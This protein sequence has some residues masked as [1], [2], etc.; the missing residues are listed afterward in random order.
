MQHF[1]PTHIYY[2]RCLVVFGHF[3]PMLYENIIKRL[4]SSGTI[5]PG[6]M[7]FNLNSD[8]VEDALE[9]LDRELFSFTEDSANYSRSGIFTS[10]VVPIPIDGQAMDVASN[11]NRK[12]WGKAFAE[13]K[14]PLRRIDNDTEK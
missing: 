11:G 13:Q 4:R 8:S 2:L 14:R 1:H 12:I 3:Q 6:D 5:A 9:H 7:R 10:N